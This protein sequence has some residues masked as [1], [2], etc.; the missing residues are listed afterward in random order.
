M[1]SRLGVAAAVLLSPGA[2][3]AA[4]DPAVASFGLACATLAL[5][6]VVSAVLL[7]LAQRR[8]RR[9]NGERDRAAAAL[10]QRDA[11][12][13]AAP[14]ALYRWD[15]RAGSESFSAGPIAA[16]GAANGRRLPDILARL[17]PKDAAV[18]EAAVARMRADGSPFDLP[19]TIAAS[20]AALDA[21]G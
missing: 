8:I 15:H 18:L 12:L 20:D 16:L 14:A 6:V 7:F 13:A 3:H 10:A 11:M 5:L 21:S 2:A 4:S 17:E 19:V 1:R 9:L